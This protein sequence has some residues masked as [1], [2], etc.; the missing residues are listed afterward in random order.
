MSSKS[1]LHNWIMQVFALSN[2]LARSPGQVKL[3]S[4]K[5]KLWTNILNTGK[6]IFFSKFGFRASRWKRLRQRLS[7]DQRLAVCDLW[8]S[9]HDWKMWPYIIC[10]QLW[11]VITD[12][13]FTTQTCDHRLSVHSSNM[14]SHIICSQLWHVITD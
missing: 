13:L 5:W 9:L 11:H 4:D 7:C 3:D 1:S 6:W 12:Y 8:L 2:P 14:W 10:S